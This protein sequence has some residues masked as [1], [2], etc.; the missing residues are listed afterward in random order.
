MSDMVA[1]AIRAKIEETI[2][3]M[4]GLSPTA[5]KVLSLVDN[6]DASPKEL[7]RVIR[8]DPVLTARVLKLINSAHFG[9]EQEVTSINRALVILGL[10]TVK[11]LA[12][13][14]AVVDLMADQTRGSEISAELWS[15]CLWVGVAARVISRL[16]GL[17]RDQQELAFVAGLLHDLG[18]VCM[19]KADLD[20]YVNV[21]ESIHG[22][23]DQ[24]EAETETF[25]ENH[26]DIGALLAQRW[27][28]PEALVVGIRHHHT[29]LVDGPH[30]WISCTIHLANEL[31][32]YELRPVS[33][34]GI[35]V[36]PKPVK[37]V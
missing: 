31:F 16:R 23:R 28:F 1:S 24:L 6:I 18:E 14:S 3:N 4:P 15:H 30:A 27:G 29:P 33:D 12:L 5:S 11:N 32:F 25:G 7:I 10:N 20:R 9:M 36:A 8:M 19:L 35:P 26:Q 22:G 34:D 2:E 21:V 13:S 37:P 17:P